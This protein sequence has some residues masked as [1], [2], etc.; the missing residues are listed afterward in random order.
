MGKQ[1]INI[2]KCGFRLIFTIYINSSYI[3]INNQTINPYEFDWLLA[4]PHIY[5]LTFVGVQLHL[6]MSRFLETLAHTTYV[7]N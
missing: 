3:W 7:D 6:S 4:D 1:K 2:S 5:L